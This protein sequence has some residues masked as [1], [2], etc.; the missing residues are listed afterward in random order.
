VHQPTVCADP[1]QCVA[2][3]TDLG[4]GSS[5][6]DG[7]PLTITQSPASP[8]GL[9]EQ[10]VSV[11]VSDGAHTS[12]CVSQ[13]DVVDCEP[14]VLSC[15]ANF[16]A[17]CTGGGGAYITP[18]PADA[19]DNCGLATVYGQPRQRHVLI[20]RAA[21]RQLPRRR[22]LSALQLPCRRRR[23]GALGVPALALTNKYRI[24]SRSPP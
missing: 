7:Q 20:H 2:S 22:D 19:S 17:Q 12:Q 13:L 14:P 3:V 16:N 10:T 8:Y 18:L 9:G 4:A 5:D 6:P 21:H 24:A 1:G 11:S 15:P 23:T